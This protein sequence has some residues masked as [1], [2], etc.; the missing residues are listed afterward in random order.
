MDRCETDTKVVRDLGTETYR[1][2]NLETTGW[3]GKKQKGREAKRLRYG[4]TGCHNGKLIEQRPDTSRQRG[5]EKETETQRDRGI[6][7]CIQTSAGMEPEPKAATRRD[8]EAERHICRDT[9]KQND[10]V[11]S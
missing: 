9:K 7:T 8:S 1:Q 3:S 4:G 5:S 2:R 6:G 10:G 11:T